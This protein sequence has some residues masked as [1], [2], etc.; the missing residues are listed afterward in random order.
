MTLLFLSGS[1]LAF[2]HGSSF[3][4][5]LN[6]TQGSLDLICNTRP[7]YFNQDTN[8]RLILGI[9]SLPVQA[10]GKNRPVGAE[11]FQLQF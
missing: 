7:K 1:P 9:H 3:L 2:Q 4:Q 6:E 10:V 8:Q 11:L 5:Q